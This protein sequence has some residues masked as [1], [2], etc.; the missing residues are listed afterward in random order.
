MVK[1]CGCD[2]YG[3]DSD[4]NFVTYDYS[5]MRRVQQA[6]YNAR[7][8][9]FEREY[10]FEAI[11][12]PRCR[13]ADEMLFA[14]ALTSMFPDIRNFDEEMGPVHTSIIKAGAVLTPKVGLRDRHS[15]KV[16]YKLKVWVEPPK[17]IKEVIS[18]SGENDNF[19]KQTTL[20]VPYEFDDLHEMIDNVTQNLFD[21]ATN[22]YN[23]ISDL[24]KK[25]KEKEANDTSKSRTRKKSA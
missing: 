5:S 21:Q 7:L 19:F 11:A 1:K 17:K 14:T 10:G 3:V 25:A 16:I 20:E 18:P 2:V 12:I 24:Y 15:I 8:D 23:S 22:L 9:E 4:D 6:Y 13:K